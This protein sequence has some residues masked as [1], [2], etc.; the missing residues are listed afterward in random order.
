MAFYVTPRL[1]HITFFSTI[2]CTCTEKSFVKEHILPYLTTVISIVTMV[3]TEFAYFMRS[4][5]LGTP[6][7]V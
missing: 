2:S 5:D 1:L 7:L 6:S 3:M 4:I